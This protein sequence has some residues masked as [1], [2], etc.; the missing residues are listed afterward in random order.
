MRGKKSDPEY[1]A[2][3]I[4]ESVAQG[5]D[6]PEQIVQRAKKVVQEIDEHIRESERLKDIRSKVLDVIFAF[7]KPVKDKSEEAKMLSFFKIEHP[8][9][10]KEIC[11]QVKIKPITL[12]DNSNL[13]YNYAVKQLLEYKVLSRIGNQLIRGSRFDEYITFM[14][15]EV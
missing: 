2:S 11:S 12:Q 8:Q 4:Q 6:T 10:C 9:I 15:R 3:F 5:C 7:E 13:S 14:L 1:I